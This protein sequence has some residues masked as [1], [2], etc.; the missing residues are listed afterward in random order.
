MRPIFPRVAI[1]LVGASLASA[2]NQPAQ[3]PR[4]ASVPIYHVTVV[5]RT[6]KAVN[7]F[8]RS[9]PTQIDFRGTVLMPEGKGGATV[10]SRQGRTDIDAN[11][12]HFK[13]PQQYGREYLTYVLW[14]ITPE[15]RPHNLG[16]IVPD[17]S[18]NSR[19]RVT[20]DLQAFAMIVTAEPYSA[21]RQPSD[22]VVL[23]N[24][25]RPD[26]EGSTETV[27][28][29]YELLPRGQYTWHINDN[30]SAELANAPKVSEREFETLT[31]LYQAEN[32]VGVAGSAGAQQYAPETLDRARQLLLE[33]QQ[34][35]SAKAESHRVIEIARQATQT[36]EDARL[37]AVQREQLENLRVAQ[38]DAAKARQN[39]AA[40][41][42]SADQA[43]QQANAAAEAQ[44]RQARQEADAAVQRANALEQRAM[45][46]RA[47]AEQAVS[48]AQSEAA[49][50]RAR[51]QQAE[52]AAV[53]SHPD[54]AREAGR[55]SALRVR[56]LEN[57]NGVLAATDTPRGLVVTISDA[58][59]SGESVRGSAADKIAR[60]SAIVAAQPGLRVSVESY[61]DSSLQQGLFERRAGAVRRVLTNNG[62]AG[63]SVS[64]SGLG[65]SRP[66]GPPGEEEN[67]R[68][69]I[70]ISGDPIGTLPF[71]DHTY[72]LTR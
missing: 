71:W 59:F 53:Q 7:Y 60:V 42:L 3:N 12:E 54:P 21:V 14:A 6:I 16:E 47:A 11:L 20:T 45:S 64:A 72:S 66:V 9:G 68:V 8:Y 24:Q 58:D 63:S 50:A 2:Q 29:K 5:Q 51:A 36:A 52:I 57:L 46:D 48:Q 55:Q 30:L 15:G 35:H 17:H 69:E 18:N 40:V 49:A 44:V 22:V 28:A 43:V 34:M 33:A 10:E 25:L 62:L 67:S 26:T 65:A 39:A 19:I 41:Q 56:L 23:E 38:N 4:D 27:N 31:E 70:V 61:S 37:I 32:A 13:P 1:V